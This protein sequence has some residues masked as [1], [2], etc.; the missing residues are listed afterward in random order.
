MG[1]WVGAVCLSVILCGAAMGQGADIG[2]NTESHDVQ[3]L[4]PPVPNY[5]FL[6][7]LFGLE[8][9]CYVRF[10][11]DE[12]GHTAN[13][14]TTCS[15]VIFCDAAEAAVFDALFAPKRIEGVPMA[16]DNIVYPLEFSL[17]D[18]GPDGEILPE[19]AEEDRDWGSMKPCEEI[20]V[21]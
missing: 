21:S 7:Q 18:Y 15:K 8:G 2:E 10:T 20:P 11:V 16:R 13:H 12:L 19:P 6:A 17:A 14:G 5:P 9:I 4:R 1:H 3:V